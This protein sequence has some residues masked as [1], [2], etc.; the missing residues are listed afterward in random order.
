MYG[1]LVKLCSL[2]TWGGTLSSSLTY[3]LALLAA[4]WCATIFAAAVVK[5]EVTCASVLCSTDADG[6]GDIDC[7][8]ANGV[9]TV[10]WRTCVS[11]THVHS[12]VDACAAP[13]VQ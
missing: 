2:F 5:L 6:E 13:L 7:S 10:E 9:F 8:T 4:A 3:I 12:P 1:I 11:E